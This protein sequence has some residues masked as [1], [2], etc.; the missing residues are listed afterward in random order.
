VDS[1]PSKRGILEKREHGL[2]SKGW[3][4]ISKYPCLQ[5]QKKR[6]WDLQAVGRD[7]IEKERKEITLFL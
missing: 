4:L 7:S 6:G 3:N 5:K 1:L 2:K